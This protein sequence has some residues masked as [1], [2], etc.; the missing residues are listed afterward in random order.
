MCLFTI[1]HMCLAETEAQ[2]VKAAGG[3]SEMFEYSVIEMKRDKGG[4]L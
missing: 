4:G 2:G 3:S 1:V